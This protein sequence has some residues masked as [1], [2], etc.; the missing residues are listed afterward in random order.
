[1]PGLRLI[2]QQPFAALRH[3]VRTVVVLS[4]TFYFASGEEWDES[5]FTAYPGRNNMAALV[6]ALE[7]DGV[8]FI[9]A[10]RRRGR[11]LG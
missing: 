3:E 11:G 4:G 7:D 1:L 8:E 6:R 10:P 5:K 2:A 9:P